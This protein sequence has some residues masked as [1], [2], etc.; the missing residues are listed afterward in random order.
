[1]SLCVFQ[2]ASLPDLPKNHCNEKNQTIL[3]ISSEQGKYNCF[4]LVA[5]PLTLSS[6]D[7]KTRNLMDTPSFFQKSQIF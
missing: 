4:L 3:L 6:E 1:V 2:A 7:F 5:V